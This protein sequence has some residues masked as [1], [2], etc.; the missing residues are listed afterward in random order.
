MAGFW[1][2]PDNPEITIEGSDRQSDFIVFKTH[3]LPS[4]L[5][6]SAQDIYRLVYVVMDPRDVAVSGGFFF[7]EAF[8][9][10]CLN[11]DSSRFSPM[12]NVICKGG[13]PHWL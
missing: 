10:Y 11:E 1:K 3:A 5:R 8:G 13:G 4:Q 7:K 12:V 9:K 2:Q 6:S